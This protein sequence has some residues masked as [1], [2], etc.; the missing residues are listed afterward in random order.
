MLF[1]LFVEVFDMMNNLMALD[2]WPWGDLFWNMSVVT[3]WIIFAFEIEL[4]NEKKMKTELPLDQN[5]KINIY[6]EKKVSCLSPGRYWFKMLGGGKGG[7]SAGNREDGE[8]YI[9]YVSSHFKIIL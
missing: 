3:S 4:F 7:K 2:N 5:V 6:S 9:H 1:G 8:E